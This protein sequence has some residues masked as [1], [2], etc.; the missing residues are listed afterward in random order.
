MRLRLVR[1]KTAFN[2]LGLGSAAMALSGGLIL[3]S[4]LLFLTMGLNFGIDFRGG[5]MITAATEAPEDVA[6]YRTTLA[7]L[8]IGDFAVTEIFDPAAE[9]TG[10]IQ[11]QVTIRIEQEGDDPAIQADTIVIVKDA[12][13]ARFPGINFVQTDSVGAKVSGELVRAGAIAVV[14]AIAAVLFYIWVRF[15][16]QFSVGAVAA[17]VHDVVLTIGV[18]SLVL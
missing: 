10:A 8:D 5:T 7:G 1:E 9:L 2:F 11:N 14:L 18:F 4:V 12:L 16:W 6:D 13:E 17:L 15:D 3:A